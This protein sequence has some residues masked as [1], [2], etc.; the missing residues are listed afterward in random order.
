MQAIKLDFSR[1]RS[2]PRWIA[3]LLLAVALAF[4]GDVAV[5]FFKVL[6][7]MKKNEAVLAQM[8][9]HT[10]GA[11]RKVAPEEIAAA[12]ETM[13]RLSTPWDKLFAA[14]ESAASD[15]VALLSIEPDAKTGTVRISG[16]SKDYLAALT[17]VL[18]LSRADSLS[19]VQLARHEIKQNDPHKTVGFSVSASW[20]R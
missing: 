18:N 10:Y 9:P 4:T 12:K 13:Q 19:H 14:L 11:P 16:D 20:G 7:S 3:P 17:Y 5:S 15:Q 8:S 1:R 2:A 6:R